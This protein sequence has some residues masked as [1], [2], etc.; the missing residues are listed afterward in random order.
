MV[1][2]V[3]LE[4][5]LVARLPGGA[6]HYVTG[7]GLDAEQRDGWS[8]LDLHIDLED[9]AEEVID[10]LTE[11]D[12]WAASESED[13]G[14]QVV[15]LVL[16]DGRRLDLVVEGGRVEVPVCTADNEI[17]MVAALAMTKLGRGDRLIGMHLTLELMRS[18]LVQAMVLRDRAL[19]TTVHRSRSDLDELAT[20]VAALL[21]DPVDVC[22]R[23][24]TIERVVELYG[25]WRQQ[26][27]PDYMPDWSG[28]RALLVRGLSGST[29]VHAGVG[30][31]ESVAGGAG[32]DDVAVVGES[33][34]DG[35]AEAGVG[36]GL[37]PAGE[38]FV[39]GDRDG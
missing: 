34:D 13:D 35:G 5:D 32:F 37:G 23:P 21:R 39:A 4:Q 7:S 26:L 12:V 27:E 24:N 14:R 9:S 2:Q 33:V 1:W 20:E 38:R 29:A 8:D 3:R 30:V 28:L 10:L 18:C 11:L 36:E 31:G 16:V 25:R 22:V 19:G 17:R 6:S 15:R